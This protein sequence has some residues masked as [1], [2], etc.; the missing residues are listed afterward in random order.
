APGIEE[1]R[2]C[3][4]GIELTEFSPIIPAI[5]M[6]FPVGVRVDCTAPCD[7]YSVR[8][9]VR[10]PKGLIAS[11]IDNRCPPIRQRNAVRGGAAHRTASGGCFTSQASPTKES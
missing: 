6:V 2:R 8:L 9:M 5:A 4:G 11:A 10:P 1:V 7:P 3:R